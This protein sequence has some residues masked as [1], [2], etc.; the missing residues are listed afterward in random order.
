VT[1]F[2][3]FTLGDPLH[4]DTTLPPLVN[5]QSVADIAY[6]VE[7]TI[8]QGAKLCTGGEMMTLGDVSKPQFYLPTILTNVSKENIAFD[9]EFF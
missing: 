4:P 3:G 6:T 5:T 2:E 1:S 9:T 7:E 8:S